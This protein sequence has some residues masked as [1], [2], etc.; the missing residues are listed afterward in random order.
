MT[1]DK[2]YRLKPGDL[3]LVTSYTVVCGFLWRGRCVTTNKKLGACFNTHCAY[4]PIFPKTFPLRI[5]LLLSI[6]LTVDNRAVRSCKRSCQNA[7]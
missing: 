1:Y 7:Q 2:I 5:Y 6:H 3:L 4:R